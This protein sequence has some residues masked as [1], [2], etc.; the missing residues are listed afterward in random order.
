[1]R[2]KGL[3]RAKRAYI[4]FRAVRGHEGLELR[5]YGLTGLS[6]KVC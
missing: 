3:Y 5:V 4:G 2:I 1:M 6:F